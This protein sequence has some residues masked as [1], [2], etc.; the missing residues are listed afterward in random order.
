[1]TQ[2]V[3]AVFERTGGGAAWKRRLQVAALV[4]LADLALV[5]TVGW[6]NA[7]RRDPL[8]A[9]FAAYY[10]IANIGWH[11]GWSHL[12][13]L[14]AQQ[15]EFDALG[16]LPWYPSAQTPV[17][18][19]LVAP[20]TFLPI[21]VAYPLWAAL[22]LGA[23]VYGWWLAAGGGRL[24]R[25]IQLAAPLSLLPMATAFYEGQAVLLVVALICLCWWLLRRHQ[26]VAAGLALALA[27]ALKPQDCLLL[28]A[29]LLV[30]GRVRLLA[31]WAVGSA[32]LLGLS[33]LVVGPTGLGAY[34]ERLGTASGSPKPWIVN[35]SMTV[36]ALLGRGPLAWAAQLLLA[37]A[38]LTVARI[39]RGR[40]PE[41]PIVAGILGSL[42]LSPFLHEPDVAVLLPAAWLYLRTT[43][44]AWHQAVVAAGWPAAQ[45]TLAQKGWFL[46]GLEV[47]LLGALLAQPLSRAA[48]SASESAREARR[49]R[50][51]A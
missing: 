15:R 46:I 49:I 25:A 7:A 1:M 47:L 2:A 39:H 36:A 10:A 37:A 48:R 42:L 51:G 16:R 50:T 44:P 34:L 8:G 19:F 41:I 35:D 11:Q 21:G 6:I 31:A 33:L 18:A 45:L 23:F 5:V 32:A 27:T 9:D 26:E 43:P 13:D 29:A 30:G 4:L 20:F 12:Y 17:L 22:M 24:S 38:A 40:G 3:L 14:A 28:P